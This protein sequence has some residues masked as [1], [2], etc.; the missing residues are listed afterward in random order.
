MSSARF[1]IPDICEPAEMSA[2]VLGG[3]GLNLFRLKERGLPVPDFGVVS[4]AAYDAWMANCKILPQELVSKIQAT[5]AS[6]GASY[7]AVRSSMTSE[8]GASHSYAGMMESFLYV[9]PPDLAAMVVRCFESMHTTRVQSY[10]QG[11]GQKVASQ[12][13][14]VVVQRMVNSQVSGVAFSR[15]PVG[16]SAL[17]HIEA[18]LGLGEGVVS[19]LVDVDSYSVDR[20]QRVVRETVTTKRTAVAFDSESQSGARVREV[21]VPPAIGTQ[22]AL[23][24]DQVLSLAQTVI[25]LEKSFGGPMDVEWAF[26]SPKDSPGEA[27]L[28]LL[29]IRPITQTFPPLV[30]YVDT[31]LS[32]SYPGVTSTFTSTFVALGYTQI[33]TEAFEYLGVSNK[34][35]VQLQPHL[36]H[37]VANLGGHMYYNLRSYYVVLS[38]MPGGSTNVERWHHMIGGAI[39][40]RGDVDSVPPLH[41]TESLRSYAALAKMYLLHGRIFR[42]FYRYT[43]E[44]RQRLLTRLSTSQNSREIAQFMDHALRTTKGF[45]L[46]G[47]NDFLIM[48]LIKILMGRLDAWGIP[49]S[50]LPTLVKTKHGVD[51]L[52][53]LSD[54]R[55]LVR[56][57]GDQKGFFEVFQQFLATHRHLESEFEGLYDHLA[58]YLAE[59]GYQDAATGISAYLQKWGE[60]SFEELKLESLTLRQSPALLLD[61]MKLIASE[62][63][64]TSQRGLAKAR[65]FDFSRLGWGARLLCRGLLYYTHKTIA[66]REK[67]RLIRGQY[68]GL[69]RDGMLRLIQALRREHPALFDGFTVRDFFEISFATAKKY[70]EGLLSADDLA[71]EI[72]ERKRQVVPPSVFPETLCLAEGDRVPT[73]PADLAQDPSRYA[74]VGD[75]LQGLGASPGQVEGEVLA[76]E[77]PDQA[78]KN[79]DLARK[80]LVT[81]TTDPAWV[82]IMSQCSGLISEKGS[83]LS[84]TAIIGREMG[85]PTVVGVS[86]V[87]SRLRSGDRV[88]IDGKS[89]AITVLAHPENPSFTEAKGDV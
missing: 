46:T 21:S 39:E 77:A 41:W 31:N 80:I 54:L 50:E 76:L 6:W 12:R 8:D 14:A 58:P 49:Q 44:N 18:G 53:P 89:G 68:F 51:S 24:H 28:F 4:T 19:G 86:Q 47:L 9:A 61:L 29:Q 22:T 88:R 25:H 1:W 87:F 72:S 78:L 26:E 11:T 62:E 33:F 69:M 40:S 65:S 17:V 32:E 84:H 83:L 35:L 48:I 27:R 45:G 59:R 30:S 73:F 74:K 36:D 43:G 23:T 55:R 81:R 20:F 64:T 67:T 13:A 57:L 3:K 60:R 85:I 82:F 52:E 75:D 7:V 71:T 56:S 10:E 5:V 34:R 38:S 15:A 79:V 63:G 42:D 70:G 16:D 37:L 2:S 66:T